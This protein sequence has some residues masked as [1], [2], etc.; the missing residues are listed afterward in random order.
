MKYVLMVAICCL[1]MA[2]Q[3]NCAGNVNQ[4]NKIQNLLSQVDIFGTWK[5]THDGEPLTAV[6]GKKSNGDFTGQLTHGT[7]KIGP[8]GL[9]I[10][11][12]G[13]TYSLIVY[14]QEA[15]IKVMTP[16]KVEITLP[17]SGNPKVVVTKQ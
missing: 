2:A 17:F 11:D 3:A 5:G 10:C 9:Q 16:T 7:K 4:L 14:W 1:S 12:Y 13:D 15:E 8:T 6:L